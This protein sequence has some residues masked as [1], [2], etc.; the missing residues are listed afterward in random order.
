VRAGVAA[1]AE[2]LCAASSQRL[3]HVNAE[4]EGAVRSA[5]ATAKQQQVCVCVHVCMVVWVCM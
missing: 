2:S 1:A 5:E 3:G 4:L